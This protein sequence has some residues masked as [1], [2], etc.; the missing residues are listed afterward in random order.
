MLEIDVFARALTEA[1]T[2]DEVRSN[3]A[4]IGTF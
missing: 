3:L 1:E 4:K 2:V